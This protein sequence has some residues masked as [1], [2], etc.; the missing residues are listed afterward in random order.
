[1]CASPV[2]MI[3]ILIKFKSHA[4]MPDTRKWM[5]AWICVWEREREL[6]LLNHSASVTCI[7]PLH[8]RASV[9]VAVACGAY[10]RLTHCTFRS[11]SSVVPSVPSLSLSLPLCVLC[12]T[13][14]VQVCLYSSLNP[15][16]CMRDALAATSRESCHCFF[17]SPSFLSLFLP[18]RVCDVT[19]KRLHLAKQWTSQWPHRRQRHRNVHQ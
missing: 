10:I 5:K 11:I 4:E 12:F 17:S 8:M 16:T 15:L 14:C 19:V 6:L 1:M 9:A 18:L 3:I 2:E 7:L 13:M